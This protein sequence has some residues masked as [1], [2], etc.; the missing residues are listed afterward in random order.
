LSILTKVAMLGLM[1]VMLGLMLGLML[2][3][4]LVQTTTTQRLAQPLR[5]P[6]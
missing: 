2:E 3:A 6:G 1:A 4:R 5:R